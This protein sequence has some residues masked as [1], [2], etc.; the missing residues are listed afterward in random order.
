[1]LGTQAV[2]TCI[3]IFGFGLV[4]PLGWY[5]AMLV[6]GYAFA[7][8]LVND[9]VKLLTYWVLGAIRTEPRPEAKKVNQTGFKAEPKDRILPATTQGGPA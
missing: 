5:W 9:R 7:W 6:W 1:V 3:A 4:T 8:F 2:A